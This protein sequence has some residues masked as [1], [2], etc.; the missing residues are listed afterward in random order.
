MNEK[1]FYYL[2]HGVI[3][4]KITRMDNRIICMKQVKEVLYVRYRINKT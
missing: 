2:L 4:N 3:L 1:H